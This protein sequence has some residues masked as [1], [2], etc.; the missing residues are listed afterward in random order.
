LSPP[1]TA[2]VRAGKR[3]QNKQANRAA[4]LDAARHCFHEQGYDAITVRDVIRQAG[5]AAGTFYN[6][7]PDKEALFRSLVEERIGALTARLVA[8]RRSADSIEHFLHGA[9]RTTFEEIAANPEFYAMMF[10]NE[11]IVRSYFNDSVMGLAMR[12]LKDDLADAIGRGL[13]PEMDV[14]YLSAM[15]FGAGY[16]IARMLTVRPD[17][18]PEEAAVFATRVF[19]NGLQAPA[20]QA[21]LIRR[22]P[23][24]HRGSAR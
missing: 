16:E 3:E 23:I 6:Y 10:R 9:Y 15:T 11:A 24:T 18:S 17:K 4:I 20:D 1:T 22:G 5:L 21:R 12:A 8:V 14:D 2:A 19:L 13:L 7:F